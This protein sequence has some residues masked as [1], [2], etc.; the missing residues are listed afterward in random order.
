MGSKCYSR[1]RELFQD[2]TSLDRQL[3]P[4]NE[5][6]TKDDVLMSALGS[7][8]AGSSQQ[9]NFL[10]W[11]STTQSVNNLNCVALLRQLVIMPPAKSFQTHSV[12][13]VHAGHGGQVA[14]PQSAPGAVAPHARLL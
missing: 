4:S 9:Q 3:K 13:H 14:A 6:D 12:R 5:A 1:T 7:L 8:I 11:T 10:D 2:P